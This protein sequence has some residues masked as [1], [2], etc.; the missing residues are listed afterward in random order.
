MPV[1]VVILLLQ[2]AALRQRFFLPERE[3]SDFEFKSKTSLLIS[4]NANPS[5]GGALASLLKPFR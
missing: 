3:P 2:L 4:L 5:Q 1:D